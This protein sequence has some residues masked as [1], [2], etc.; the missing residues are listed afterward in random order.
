MTPPVKCERDHAAIKLDAT[1]WN[2]L[3]RIGIQVVDGTPDD[4]GWELELR[5][6]EC[7]TTLARKVG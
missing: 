7:G 2:G 6:C 5:N 4:P 1:A 3:R